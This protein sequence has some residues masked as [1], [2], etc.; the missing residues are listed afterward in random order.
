[1]SPE[2]EFHPDAR[3]ELVADVEWYD[4]REPG[5]G[6]RFEGAARAAIEAIVNSPEAWAVWR[7]WQDEPLVRSKGVKN[8]P[9]SVVYFVQDDRIIIVAVAHTSRRPGYWQ[10]RLNPDN[11]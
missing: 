3:A 7:G 11:G 6:E 4:E 9:Y 8:F 5:L 10:S 2:F 1:M